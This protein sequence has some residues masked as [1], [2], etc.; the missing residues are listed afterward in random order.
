M[1]EGKGLCSKMEIR[2]DKPGRG[3]QDDTFFGNSEAWRLG[4]VSCVKRNFIVMCP[5]TLFAFVL[6]FACLI[7]EP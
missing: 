1:G 3:G 2:L 4:Q 6:L 7:I 5:Y